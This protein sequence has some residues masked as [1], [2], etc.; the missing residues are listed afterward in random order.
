MKGINQ[1]HK[2]LGIHTCPHLMMERVEIIFFLCY[3]NQI[4]T[5]TINTYFLNKH[6]DTKQPLCKTCPDIECLYTQGDFEFPTELSICFRSKPLSYVNTRHVWGIIM[7]FGTIAPDWIKLEEG[8]FFGVWKTGPWIGFKLPG[9]DNIAWIGGGAGN[10]F[11][12]H[13][14]RHSCFSLNRSTGRF[15]L[16]ENGK[17]VWDKTTPEVVG[18]MKKMNLTADILTLGCLYRTY[19]TMYMSMYGSVTDGQVFGRTLQDKEMEDITSFNSDLVGDIINWKNSKWNLKSPFNTTE[20]EVL[21]FEKDVC[22]RPAQGLLLVP[23][24]LNFR[25]SLHA[26]A[27]LSG[28]IVSHVDK[29]RCDEI[30]SW[31][32]EYP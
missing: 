10:S 8:F 18:W 27:R 15:K 12:F 5:K 26:C 13:V 4:H 2:I 24:K 22:S 17:K 25:E 30:Q 11:N 21:D 20:L 9:T 29:I 31:S 23:H 7:S 16:V 32:Y 6:F 19:G 3:F 14:W 1:I 28:D